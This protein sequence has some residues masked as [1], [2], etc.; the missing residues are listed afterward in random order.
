MTEVSFELKW[1]KGFEQSQIERREAI[2]SKLLNAFEFA[3]EGLERLGIESD[4][5]IYVRPAIAS[6]T[7]FYATST[8]ARTINY[9]LNEAALRNRRPTTEVMTQGLVHEGVHCLRWR[10]ALPTRPPERAAAEGVAY[11]GEY[12]HRVWA[13]RKYGGTPPPRSTVEAIKELPKVKKADMRKRFLDDILNFA[14]NDQANWDNWFM[15]RVR[16]VGV[17]PGEVVGIDSVLSHV[18]QGAK[19]GEMVTWTTAEVLGVA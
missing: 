4:E 3:G 11:V 6:P 15:W 17:S 2:R 16:Q 19:I 7:D 9:L 10:T 5:S 12:L 18:R 1:G 14:T 8:G 13:Q